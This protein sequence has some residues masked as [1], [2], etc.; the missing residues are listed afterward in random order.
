MCKC[1]IVFAPKYKRKA[2]YSQY[3]DS[4]GQIFRR[5]CSCKGVEII[6][7]RLLP[8]HVHMLVGIPS[9]MSVSSFIEHLKGKSTLMMFDKHA[10]LKHKFGNCRFWS[11]GYYVT[12][13]GLN[14]ATIASTSGS[15]RP[16]TSRWTSSA[17]R[18][19]RILLGRSELRAPDRVPNVGVSVV[20]PNARRTAIA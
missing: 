2:I 5:L 9:K 18:S 4:V 20:S 14:E 6:E 13:V 16:T 11:E 10:N 19:T 8:D 7:G 1:H 3:R 12:T 15:R 17:S